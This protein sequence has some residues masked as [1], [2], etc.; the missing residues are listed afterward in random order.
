MA[1]NSIN[2]NIEAVNC[3]KSNIKKIFYECRQYLGSF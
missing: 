3:R 1:Y 2:E